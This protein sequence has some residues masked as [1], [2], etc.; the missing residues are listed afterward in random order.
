M[1][2]GPVGSK[3]HQIIWPFW[4][5]ITHHGPLLP[6]TPLLQ[7][8]FGSRGCETGFGRGFSQL[9]FSTE[10][11]EYDPSGF[12]TQTT[13]LSSRYLCWVMNETCEEKL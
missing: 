7:A 8:H 2:G 9:T 13:L 3:D 5:A 6:P 11:G 10:R 12:P 4:P 1:I